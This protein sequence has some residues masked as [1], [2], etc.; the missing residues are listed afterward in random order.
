MHVWA[1]PAFFW[2]PNGVYGGVSLSSKNML[3]V[4]SI[5]SVIEKLKVGQHAAWQH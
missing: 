3:A 2:A 1:Q 4:G 5:A